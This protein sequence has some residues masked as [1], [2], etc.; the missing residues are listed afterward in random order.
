M[1][2]KRNML[3]SIG[4]NW[5]NCAIFVRQLNERF[6]ATS[7]P[8]TIPVFPVQFPCPVPASAGR[9]EREHAHS[10][11]IAKQSPPLPFEMFSDVKQ[12]MCNMK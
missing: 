8:L 1:P 5:I 9:E 11:T 6:P 10:A 12:N 2:Q 7:P 3:C 4:E